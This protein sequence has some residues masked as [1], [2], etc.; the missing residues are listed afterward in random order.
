M[1]I[2]NLQYHIWPLAILSKILVTYRVII[3]KTAKYSDLNPPVIE[4]TNDLKAFSLYG[5]G[6]FRENTLAHKRLDLAP[7]LSIG[8]NI[9]VFD[10]GNNVVD[11]GMVHIFIQVKFAYS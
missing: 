2:D 1:L 7:E 10:D 9:V 3:A 8:Q 4:L 5:I 6:I 11:F